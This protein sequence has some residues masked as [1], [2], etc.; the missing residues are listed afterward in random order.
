MGS[1]AE[2][3]SALQSEH[4]L[5]RTSENVKFENILAVPAQLV[6]LVA[7]FVEGYVGEKWV[8]RSYFHKTT[9][10]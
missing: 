1:T 8:F 6:T 2:V 7:L 9:Y 3:Y 4:N 5:I 10:F